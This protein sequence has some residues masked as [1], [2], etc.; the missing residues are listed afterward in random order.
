VSRTWGKNVTWWP[1]DIWYILFWV[2]HFS[3]PYLKIETIIA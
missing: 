2:N 3:T 1:F